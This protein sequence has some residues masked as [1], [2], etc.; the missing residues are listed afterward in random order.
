[1]FFCEFCEISKNTFFTEQ[2]RTTA[3][4][5]ANVFPI[6]KKGEKDLIKSYRL[7]SL[8]PNFGKFFERLL[9]NSLYK[10][11]DENELVNPVFFLKG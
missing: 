11:I 2:L 9:F 4:E 8:L 10:Y 3:S 1:M 7:V 5:K 6:D